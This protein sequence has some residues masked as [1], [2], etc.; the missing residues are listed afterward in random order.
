MFQRGE[1]GLDLWVRGNPKIS[2]HTIILHKWFMDKY[3]VDVSLEP[4]HNNALQ[5]GLQGAMQR[6]KASSGE[7]KNREPFS[8]CNF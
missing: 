1:L 6:W 7:V 4:I 8:Y 5:L 2:L 3:G